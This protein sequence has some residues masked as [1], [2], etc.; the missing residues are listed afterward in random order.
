VLGVI[1]VLAVGAIWRKR[2]LQ[3]HAAQSAAA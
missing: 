3:K 1:V 2:A